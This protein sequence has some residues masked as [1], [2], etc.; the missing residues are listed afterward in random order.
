MA[1]PKSLLIV[2]CI[3]SLTGCAETGSRAPAEQIQTNTSSVTV[4][5]PDTGNSDTESKVASN[6]ISITP[7]TELSQACPSHC[8]PFDTRFTGAYT[9]LIIYSEGGP[10]GAVQGTPLGYEPRNFLERFFAG[11]HRT[12][13]LT[14]KV[15][16]GAFAATVPLV[17][18]DHV[19]NRTSGEAFNRIIY[20]RAQNYPLF[21]IASDGS[22]EIVSTQFV[23]KASDESQSNAAG[24]TLNLIQGVASFLTPTSAVLTTLTAQNTRNVATAID[25]SLNQLLATT[26][27]EEQWTDVDIRHGYRVSVTF[28]VPSPENSWSTPPNATVGHW[29]IDFANPRPSIFSDIEICPPDK[30]TTGADCKATPA[31]AAAAAKLDAK[32][33]EVLS[34][35]LVANQPTTDTV[36]KYLMQQDWYQK[37]IASMS[38]A[39]SGSLATGVASFCR[40]IKS[41]IVGLGLNDTDASIVVGAVQKGVDL[42][43]GITGAMAKDAANCA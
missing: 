27:D 7:Y 22:N 31:E 35:H 17:T 30:A 8:V 5:T 34:F 37:D 43:S 14:A 20:H 23:V 15:N 19:S 42:S 24:E 33:A 13:T 26:I 21:L 38:S 41:A 3:L 1:I 25:Q 16:V 6:W 9:R 18:I 28:K 29:T 11:V 32:P 39:S 12:V 40:S 4:A 10:P 2:A 36:Q